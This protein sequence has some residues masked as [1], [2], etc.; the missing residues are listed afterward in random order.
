MSQDPQPNNSGEE[1]P[2][3]NRS[4][5]LI[6]VFLGILIALAVVGGDSAPKEMTR[7]ALLGHLYTCLLYTS[8]AADE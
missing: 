4:A 7:D 1:S 6:L 8:D 2:K 3:G 5:M